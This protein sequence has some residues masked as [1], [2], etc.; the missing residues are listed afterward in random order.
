MAQSASAATSKKANRS[1]AKADLVVRDL[2]VGFLDG[3]VRIDGRVV[4]A[5]SLAAGKSAVSVAVSTDAVLD[6]SDELL[7]DVLVSKIGAGASRA[8]GAR[9]PLS[10]QLP[11]GTYYLL[12]CADGGLAVRETSEANNCASQQFVAGAED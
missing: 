7:Q 11:A 2:G 8:F 5:G 4:N 1:A 12:V 10:D 3:A 6:A 9:V